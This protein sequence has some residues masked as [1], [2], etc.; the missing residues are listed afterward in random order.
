MDWTGV[1]IS[2]TKAM[3]VFF[4]VL[5][6]VPVLGWVERRGSAFIQHRLGPNRVNIFGFTLFGM[7]QLMA[8]AVKFL[9]KE[10]Y[11]PAHAN[12]AFYMLAPMLLLVPASMTFAIVPF[13]DVL[14]IG[15]RAINLQVAS[16]DVGIL[17]FFAL[18]SLAVYGIVLAGWSSN[19][20]Y[21]F[22]GG[23][24]SSAQMVSYEL[25]LGLSVVGILMIH[26]AL[27]LEKI[28]HGQGELLFGVIPAWGAV[29]QPLAFV[30][31]VV[32]IFAEAN[33]LPFDLP[34]AESELVVGYYTE[35]GAMKMGLFFMAREALVGAVGPI[36]AELLQVGSFS[37]KLVFVLW[38]FIWVRWTLPRFRYDQ[39]MDLG[40]KVVLP[41][42]LANLFVT[43]LVLYFL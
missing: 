32:A 19:N 34:E 18:S 28:V 9:F 29:T 6:A 40:W 21:S 10:D 35:Y 4:G 42:A 5:T 13:G 22:L 17:Y 31:F 23:L 41:L 37:I 43:G 1:A 30:L 25:T 15:G 36:P 3:L 16:L 24:R 26:G 7:I 38:F 27:Q 12:R 14:V 20:K 2:I 33:R 8:D 11:I 39:L